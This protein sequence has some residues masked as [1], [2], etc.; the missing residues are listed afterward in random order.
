MSNSYVGLR[1]LKRK[2]PE[3]ARRCATRLRA[4]RA[5]LA[6]LRERKSDGRLLLATW[7]IRDF[8][9]NKFGFG[10]RLPESFYYIAEILSCFDMVAVQEVTWNLGPL[11]RVMEILGREWDYIVT[12]TTV[13]VSG[14]DE[15]MA[16]LFNAE[17]VSFRK[18]AGEVVLP[19]GQLIVAASKVSPSPEDGGAPAVPDAA[20]ALATAGLG[21]V[22]Q[23]F[24]R[25]PF[26]A[27]FQAGWFKFC[28]CTVH[29]YYG[30]ESGAK[31]A[32]RIAEIRRLVKFFADRQDREK[33]Q[34]A[35]MGR[36][37]ENYVLLGDFNV[38]SPEHET[39][40]ALI[41]HGF[42]VPDA[43]SGSRIA[44]PGEHFYDQIATRVADP[45]FRVTGGGKV[46]LFET[47]FRDTEEDRAIY[48]AHV[49]SADR[50]EG[51]EAADSPEALYRK[52]RTWQLSDHAPLWVEIDTDFSDLYLA[53][54]AEA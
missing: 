51:D 20:L 36:A 40:K 16:F 35:K 26:L 9:S 42:T 4:L 10:P 11:E 22:G 6:G 54:I 25:T 49:P 18:V 28:L 31:L 33:K 27:A 3:A 1:A 29:I 41:D 50:E 24:A 5:Q 23:Q 2:D 43:I 53:E 15:R 48:A 37:P 44:R 19:S 14:N 34:A 8:D 45:R 32:R 39:M 38:V 13:G 52:W 46:A 21:E 30:A 12:D 7:N 47:L 17:K